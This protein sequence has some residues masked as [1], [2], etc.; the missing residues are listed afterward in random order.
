MR[1]FSWSEGQV[2]IWDIEHELQHRLH[3]SS[4]SD[5]SLNLSAALPGRISELVVSAGQRVKVGDPVLTLEA[6]KLYHSL[7]APV[8]GTVRQLH[9]K[10]GDIVGHGQLLVEFDAE[11]T[12]D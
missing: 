10:A 5:T 3:A 4:D 11:T 6:M 9:V 2:L 1:W 12:T 8:T 7:T